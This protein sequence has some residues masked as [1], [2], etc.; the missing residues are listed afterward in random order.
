MN[1]YPNPNTGSFTISISEMVNYK[2][3]D[4]TIIDMLGR[5]VYYK[6]HDL[7]N[8]NSIEFRNLNLDAGKYHV[9]LSYENK[10][11]GRAFFAVTGQ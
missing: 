5:S 2:N 1:L 11:I 6:S 10:A 9:V 8:E 4:V 7:R 3:V